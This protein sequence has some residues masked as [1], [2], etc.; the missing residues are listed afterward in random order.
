MGT[1]IYCDGAISALRVPQFDLLAV[2]SFEATFHHDD[3]QPHIPALVGLPLWMRQHRQ[4]DSIDQENNLARHL[5]ISTNFD[6]PGFGSSAAQLGSRLLMRKDGVNLI[7]HH[8]EALCTF[9][10]SVL[11]ESC[12]ERGILS[13]TPGKSDKQKKLFKQMATQKGFETFWNE[14]RARKASHDARWKNLPS[15]Y[16]VAR[17]GV[18]YS[19]L[20]PSYATKDTSGR[21]GAP[22]RATDAVGPLTRTEGL[23]TRGLARKREIAGGCQR[24][25]V[26]AGS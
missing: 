26:D 12:G 5:W 21:R 16:D 13:K 15:P 3:S 22:T 10:I 19:W 7:P 4:N 1:I 2:S 23:V 6:H 8:L 11:R 25:S 9:C 18:T 20:V 14:Y 24:G 17:L